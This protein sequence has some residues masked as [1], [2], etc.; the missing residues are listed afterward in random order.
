MA[1]T[2]KGMVRSKHGGKGSKAFDKDSP[3]GRMIR[4]SRGE[5][6]DD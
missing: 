1:S 4:T 6:I 2:T 5:I 3:K